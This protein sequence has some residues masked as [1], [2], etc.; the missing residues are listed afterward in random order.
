MAVQNRMVA[1]SIGLDHKLGEQDERRHEFERRTGIRTASFD[2]NLTELTEQLHDRINRAGLPYEQWRQLRAEID[3]DPPQFEIDYAR[4]QSP[5]VLEQR[6]RIAA[7]P[8]YLNLVADQQLSIGDYAKQELSQASR[9][10]LLDELVGRKDFQPC[11]ADAGDRFMVFIARDAV[12]QNMP[13]VRT[14]GAEADAY[15]W[16]AN[17]LHWITPDSQS[18][19][20]VRVW[21]RS[22]PF[23]VREMGYRPDEAVRQFYGPAGVLDQQL[24]QEWNTIRE[25]DL[26]MREYDGLFDRYDPQPQRPAVPDMAAQPR[27]PAVQTDPGGTRAFTDL[28]EQVPQE[29]QREARPESPAESRLAQVEQQLKDLAEDRDR[30]ARRVD[31]LQRGVDAVTADRDDHKRR[32]EAAQG[33]VE[34]LKNVNTRQ[35][36]E[37]TDLRAQS[38]RLVEVSAERDRLK[39]E[40][41]EAVRKLVHN[42]PERER[43]GSRQRVA[44][45]A[46]SPQQATAEDASS[47]GSIQEQARQAEA[48]ME[49]SR[50]LLHAR[51]WEQHPEDAREMI[52]NIDRRVTEMADAVNDGDSPV[53]RE[54]VAQL[55]QRHGP[56]WAQA[57]ANEFRYWWDNGGS[58]KYHHDKNLR[59]HG[60]QHDGDT[61][62]PQPDNHQPQA[63]ETLGTV[64]ELNGNGHQRPGRD[65]I[66]RSR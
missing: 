61:D 57:H 1:T 44:D 18:H 46:D 47:G 41:D 31:I 12:D 32:L 17:K 16:A 52:E 11:A 29:P 60:H 4:R 3:R 13:H 43:F 15:A 55:N 39:S 51:L 5:D 34:A 38:L 26:A 48:D 37:L 21:D 20:F 2:K 19:A 24:G 14:F 40:R 64:T 49:V 53:M 65:G 62:M 59:A 10:E 22:Q 23:D 42:T 7:M 9:D 50:A 33:Q 28:G 35:G 27:Q 36:A 25:L 66:A 63:R 30:L 54:K 58:A 45:H 56:D 6:Y 8:G